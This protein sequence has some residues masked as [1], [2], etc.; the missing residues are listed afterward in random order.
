MSDASDVLAQAFRETALGVIA[1]YQ[2]YE[3]DPELADATAEVLGRV[4][5]KHLRQTV[6]ANSND[7][8]ATRPLYALVE[9]MDRVLHA[10]PDG[11]AAV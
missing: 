7:G 11:R 3:A 2:I 10:N 1:L 5:R 6:P 8:A 4:F 9:E